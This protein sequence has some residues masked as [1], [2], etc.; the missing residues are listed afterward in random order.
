MFIATQVSLL[1]LLCGNCHDSPS[2]S[3]L[4]EQSRLGL[5]I[6]CWGARWVQGALNGL[7]ALMLLEEGAAQTAM[8][9]KT[10]REVG[11]VA[12]CC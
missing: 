8:A 2:W 9:I 1:Q 11:L 3:G 6:V 12:A 5:D 10:Y 7:A 4:Q